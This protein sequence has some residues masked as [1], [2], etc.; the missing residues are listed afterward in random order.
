[1]TRQMECFGFALAVFVMLLGQRALAAVPGDPQ[2]SGVL[3]SAVSWLQGTLMG[4][5]ATVVAVIA[6]AAVGFGMLTGRINW[7]HGAVVV[8]GCFILFGAAS[9]VGGI[10]AAATAGQY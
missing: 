6:I 9:I 4:T 8:L 10:R 5:V 1:M 3:I 2:G 7:R